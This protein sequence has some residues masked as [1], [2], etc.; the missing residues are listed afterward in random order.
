M[1]CL[2]NSRKPNGRCVAGIEL[3]GHW[4]RPVSAREHG[5]VS[6]YEREY[7]D[8]SDPRVLDVVDVPLLQPRPWHYQQENWL[9]DPQ[10]RWVRVGRSVWGDLAEVALEPG[11]LWV[12]G[13]STYAGHNDRVP[14]SAALEQN[15]SLA[16]VHVPSVQLNVFVSGEAFGD[17][18]AA[19]S[20]KIRFRWAPLRVLGNGS[21]VRAVLQVAA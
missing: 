2:A 21:P 12:N 14:F 3:G 5:A 1:V 16:L 20:G 8:G 10:R 15:W 13:D 17:A 18:R 4:I 6:E 7:A 11:P 9:L 19:S